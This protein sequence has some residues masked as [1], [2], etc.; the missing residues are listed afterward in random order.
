MKEIWSNSTRKFHTA[1]HIEQDGFLRIAVA[2]ARWAIEA[3]QDMDITDTETGE[4]YFVTK[5]GNIEYIQG[6]FAKELFN[7]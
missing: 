4:V 1:Y 7:I 6:D 3:G 5:H 2:N